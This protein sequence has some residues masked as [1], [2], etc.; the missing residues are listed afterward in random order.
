MDLR[1]RGC[2][3]V[4]RKSA[5][6]KASGRKAMFRTA[7][8]RSLAIALAAILAAPLVCAQIAWAQD[9]PPVRIRGTVERIDGAT[10]VVKAR[11]GVELKVTV[12]DN[13]QIAGVIKASLSDNKILLSASP[14]CRSPTTV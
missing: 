5:A 1:E 9:P 14:R 8:A 13:A 6:K 12:A 3:A 2:N 4:R 11:D 10:S 7:F